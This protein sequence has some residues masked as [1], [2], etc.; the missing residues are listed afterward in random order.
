MGDC[1]TAFVPM[2][3]LQLSVFF[4]RSVDL[5]PYV[6][7]KTMFPP[8]LTANKW[9]L[10]TYPSVCPNHEQFLTRTSLP[11]VSGMSNC[12]HMIILF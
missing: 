3:F 6:S 5:V 1:G 9:T 10:C 8:Q 11:L 7:S 4:R 2:N 12:D